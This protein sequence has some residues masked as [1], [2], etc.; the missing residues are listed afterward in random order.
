LGLLGLSA[1]AGLLYSFRKRN[2]FIRG[3]TEQDSK[4]ESNNGKVA[5]EKTFGQYGLAL[6]G[7]MVA[8]L[9]NGFFFNL[10]YYSWFWDL[11]ILNTVLWQRVTSSQART[12][13]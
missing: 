11:I 5:Q 12:K 1:F 6:E 10:L 4:E 7:S 2:M 13:E 9:A 3:T 8:F